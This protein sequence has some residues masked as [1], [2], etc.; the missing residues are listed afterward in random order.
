MN[1]QLIKFIELCLVD[2]VISDKE[3]EVIFRKSKELGVDDD[4]CEIILQGMTQQREGLIKVNDSQNVLQ[5]PITKKKVLELKFNDLNQNKIIEIDIDDL[6]LELNKKEK[7]LNETKIEIQNFIKSLK[8]TNKPN[9]I[10]NHYDF[11]RDPLVWDQHIHIEGGKM[12]DSLLTLLNIDKSYFNNT[13]PGIE[14]VLLVVRIRVIYNYFL[15]FK[16]ENNKVMRFMVRERMSYG[17]LDD[18]SKNY[19]RENDP[20]KLL[21][22][23]I[24]LID[25]DFLKFILRDKIKTIDVIDLNELKEKMLV[26]KK[27]QENMGR[28]WD[29]KIINEDLLNKELHLLDYLSNESSL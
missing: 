26:I 27:H 2:G 7:S 17:F 13:T 29:V 14:D 20:Y 24:N 19:I 22:S 15:I 18:E 16:Q 9:K 28:K 12:F 11:I 6:S 10:K 23:N 5:K 8:K 1:E 21:S 4:E 3:R 25:K